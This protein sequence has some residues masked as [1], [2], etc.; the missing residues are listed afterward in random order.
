MWKKIIFLVL[1]FSG[2][3]GFGYSQH[4]S[5]LKKAF[6]YGLLTDD[7]EVLTKEDMNINACVATAEAF[8]EDSHSYPYWQCFDSGTSQLNCE[9]RKY[10]PYEKSRMT[11]L[12]V[13][14]KLNGDLH[15]YLYRRTMPLRECHLFKKEWHRLLMDQKYVCVSGPFNSV[16]K[17]KNGRTWSWVFD[18]YKTKKGWDGSY[19]G[20]CMP[21]EKSPL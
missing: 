17:N 19:L 11:L 18:R 3:H 7:F 21:N 1:F 4:L 16:R 20:K 13:S 14:A 6:P 9:G 2:V 5:E 12:I 10:D 15:E 8:S